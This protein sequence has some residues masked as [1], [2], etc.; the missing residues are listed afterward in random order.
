MEY[1]STT[2]PDLLSVD[3]FEQDAQV[4]ARIL[5]GKIIQMRQAQL[6]LSARIIETEAY[7]LSDKAS[8]ASLGYTASRAALFGPPGMIYMYYARGGDSLNFSCQG[9][10]N[11]VLIKAAYPLAH[12]QQN[13][14]DIRQMQQNNPLPNDDPRPSSKLCQGQT[15][16]C[17]S[18]GIKVPEWN[19]QQLNPA[20]LRLV[21]DGY[22]P[23]TIIQTT[24]LGINPQRDAHLPYRFID[25]KYS[26]Y[27]T[28]NP[29][30][31]RNWR[32]GKEYL[33]LKP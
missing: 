10:G 22:E 15:L 14:Q 9:P 21:A 25:T 27:S 28:R 8:H 2:T 20:A 32:N 6:W 31:V 12:P 13:L 1:L 3:L 11:A 30:R 26:S 24:R 19:G 18:L 23:A 4:V 16:L 33:I 17:R 7:Y 5:L 29:L